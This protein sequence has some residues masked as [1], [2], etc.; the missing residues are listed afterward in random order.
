MKREAGFTLLEV[1]VATATALVI[2]ATTLG[3]LTD[4]I[5]TTDSVALMA[6]VQDNLRASMDAMAHDIIQSGEGIPSGGIT[7]PTTGAGASVINRPGPVASTF[8][9]TYTALPVL[10]PGA[11]G[12]VFAATPNP[13]NLNTVVYGQATDTITLTYADT[14]LIDNSVNPPHTLNEFPIFLAPTAAPGCAPGNPNPAPAGA[15]AASGASVTFDITCINIG[16]GSTGIHAGDLIMFQNPRGVAIQ[17][18]TS[19][20]G[21]TVNF[22]VNDAFN[23][24]STGLTNGTIQNI[25][26]S[27]CPGSGVYPP[28]TATRVWMITYYISNAD[29]FHPQL[30]RQV[31]FNA[32]TPVGDAMENMQITYDITNPVGTPLPAVNVKQPIA[33]DTPNQIR[34]VNLF[35]AARS[36]TTNSQHAFLR[37]NLQTQ[38]SIRNLAFFNRYK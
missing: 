32:P 16:A 17:T 36:E 19:V 3:A 8:P 14:T 7:I 38:V 28:T 6:G 5:H 22:A 10:I 1:M 12:G 31:N 9:G 37:D 15:L 11:G 29:P 26:T 27:C 2:M 35:L 18:V 21:Q 34:K 20:A 33:P 25:Q 24:N 13:A 30:M 4:A 23:F